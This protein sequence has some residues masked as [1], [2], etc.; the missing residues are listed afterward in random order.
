M[1]GGAV[2]GGPEDGVMASGCSIA[3]VYSSSCRRKAAW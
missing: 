1:T 3:F 2:E